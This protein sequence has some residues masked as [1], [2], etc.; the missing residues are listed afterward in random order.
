MVGGIVAVVLFGSLLS[1]G[2][3][4]RIL[5][6]WNEGLSG[7]MP[8]IAYAAAGGAIC[9]TLMTLVRR[10]DQIVAAGFMLL[11]AGGLGLHNTYQTSLVAAG[12][13]V[14]CLASQWAPGHLPNGIPERA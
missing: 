10:G 7:T 12:L 8:A 1:S 6:L 11:V 4:V 2:S 3:T 5:L 13:S 14:I 9:L